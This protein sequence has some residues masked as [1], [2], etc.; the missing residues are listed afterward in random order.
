M[1]FRIKRY[2]KKLT[3]AALAVAFLMAALYFLSDVSQELS[4]LDIEAIRS[5]SVDSKCR[6]LAS[7]DSKV[8]CIELIQS[9]LLAISEDKKCY[10]PSD[11]ARPNHEP[12]AF[13]ERGYGC[14]FDR[15]RFIEKALQYYGMRVRHVSVFDELETPVFLSLLKP[16]IKSHA[17]SEVHT[18]RGWVVVDSFDLFIGMDRSGNI[19]DAKQMPSA[20]KDETI[21]WAYDVPKNFKRDYTAVYGLYSRH[22]K[23][24]PPYVPVPDVDWKQVFISYLM[25]GE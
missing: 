19:Y 18:D 11:V 13:L 2:R 21:Q 24:Y 1:A 4:S 22:G 12:F 25:L 23:F 16:G 3:I 15:S 5:L 20:H 8:S 10:E 17:F 14:C 6:N 9:R 7:F